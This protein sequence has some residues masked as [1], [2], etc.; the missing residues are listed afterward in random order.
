M[1]GDERAPGEG[2]DIGSV[3]P[4]SEL[5]SEPLARALAA[6]QPEAIGR[7]LRHDV[8][9]VPLM[10]TPEGETQLRVFEAPE[11]SARPYEVCLFSS[12]AT[13]AAFLADAPE[14]RFALQRGPTLV[15]F[16]EQHLAAIERVVFD[17]AGPHP[18]TATP[19]DVLLVLAPQPGD[20]DVAWV[21]GGADAE[22]PSERRRP[23][24]RRRRG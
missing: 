15:G 22:P 16:L 19:E 5:G 24:W 11:G 17:P 7:A 23:W 6:Q 9:V 8:V 1:T 14:R 3:A 4:G 12:T 20:D 18:M 2:D 10:T 13:L 21:A